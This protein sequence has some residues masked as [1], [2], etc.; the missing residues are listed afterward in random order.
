MST[1]YGRELAPRG[2]RL[3]VVSGGCERD[4]VVESVRCEDRAAFGRRS[5]SWRFSYLGGL[6]GD[7]YVVLSYPIQPTHGRLLLPAGNAVN[8]W[9]GISIY[10]RFS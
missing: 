2:G 10:Q 9:V 7:A 8:Q 1:E 6:P 4:E 5:S 3:R